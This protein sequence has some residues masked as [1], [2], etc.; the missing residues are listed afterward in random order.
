LAN[1]KV[2]T[3]DGKTV[4]DYR[5]KTFFKKSGGRW[6]FQEITILGDEPMTGSTEKLTE[7]EMA[8]LVEQAN[9]DRIGKLSTAET[10]KEKDAIIEGLAGQASAMRSKLEIQGD[11]K[12]L[13]TAQMWYK[14]QV[15]AVEKKYGA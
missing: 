6:L 14:E 2:L 5:G 13:E 9:T 1:N 7:S 3:L 8:E 4:A 12:A 11:K 10:T 15:A